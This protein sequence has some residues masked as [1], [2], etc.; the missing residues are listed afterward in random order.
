MT[1]Q[2]VLKKT[3]CKNLFFDLVFTA[4]MTTKSV[5]IKRT[6]T[7]S[8]VILSGRAAVSKTVKESVE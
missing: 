3:K 4:N 1:V 2:Q 5:V 6:I 8:N 7:S